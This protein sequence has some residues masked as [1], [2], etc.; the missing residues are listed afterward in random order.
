MESM[1]TRKK[2]VIESEAMINQISIQE[3]ANE[4]RTLKLK[5]KVKTTN[6]ER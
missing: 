6:L 2:T 3:I 4:L 1:F 5:E